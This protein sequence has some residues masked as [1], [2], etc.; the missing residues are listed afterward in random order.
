[1]TKYKHV[2]ALNPYFAHTTAIMDLVPPIGLEYIVASMK[3][4]VGKVTQLD[5][6]QEKAYQDP[7]TSLPTAAVAKN[8]N[9]FG[10]ASA[11]S[12]TPPMAVEVPFARR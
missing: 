2:L 9:G 6:R 8:S 3:D 5:L 1:M 10:I 4:L 11:A 7:A 12:S